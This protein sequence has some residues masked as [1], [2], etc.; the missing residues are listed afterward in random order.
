MTKLKVTFAALTCVV[1]TAFGQNG[2][3][4]ENTG[5]SGR[6][7]KI[8]SASVMPGFIFQNSPVASLSDFQKL[9]P[10]S[11]LLNEN[12][13]GYSS[14]GGYSASLG[15][16]FNANVGIVKTDKDGAASSHTELRLGVSY[17]GMEMYNYVNKTDTKRFD[18]LTSSQTGQTE[19]VDSVTYRNY[20][21]NYSTQQIRV[22]IS[23]IYRTNPLARWSMF[24][25]IGIEFGSSIKA[26]TS[27][28]YCE[29]SYTTSSY[30]SSSGG[31]YGGN[32]GSACRYET[33]VNKAN[34]GG[35]AYL[36]I[37]VDFR[38]GNKRP[39]FKQMHFFYEAR[40]FV[41]YMNIPELGTSTSV[42]IKS[43][44][45]LRVTI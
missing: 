15:T 42:G 36:P 1:F 40:P 23:A 24:A 38:V 45:G 35:A 22:D 16:S 37:G 7:I 28:N 34:I 12:M 20:S 29:Y 10:Q 30:N 41:N 9:Y 27:V 8:A 2:T 19:Y 6:K 43:G 5:T 33:A 14:S 26:S 4:P 18:T 44:I 11:I 17:S 32:N 31:G 13:T 39:F 3:T 21:M 25:G